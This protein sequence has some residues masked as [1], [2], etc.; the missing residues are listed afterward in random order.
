VDGKVALIYKINKKIKMNVNYAVGP[1]F[2]KN[3]DNQKLRDQFLINPVFEANAIKLTYTHYDRMIAGGIM[4]T[5]QSLSLGRYDD[6]LKSEYFL[7]RRE[8]GIINVGGSGDI[9][10][11]GRTFN[12][13]KLSCLY[14]GK[15]VKDVV[16]KSD[17]AAHPAKYFVISTPAHQAYPTTLMDAHEASPIH[18]GDQKTA[19]KRTIYK[20]IHKDGIKSCQLV[21]GATQ[22]NEGNIWNTMPPHVHDRRSE[23]YLYFDIPKDQGVFHLMGQPSE[24][25]T[26]ILSNEQAIISPPW[27]IHAGAGTSSYSFVWSMGGENQDFTDMDFV[28]I[29]EL[30]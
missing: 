17:D 28:K 20:Y 25:R 22:L 7:E 27:S 29:N 10:A 30:A 21:M 12:L 2:I 1:D 6:F 19:N 24:I 23:I 8:I 4:P 16:F 15:G 14:L 3:A 9:M 18:L 26:L 11:E 5:D 13:K